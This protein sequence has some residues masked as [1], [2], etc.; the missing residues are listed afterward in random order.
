CGSLNEGDALTEAGVLCIGYLPDG[1]YTGFFV[2]H[3]ELIRGNLVGDDH[4]LPSVSE[5]WLS[6]TC[7]IPSSIVLIADETRL[8]N[9]RDVIRAAILADRSSEKLRDV[10]ITVANGHTIRLSAVGIDDSGEPFANSSSLSLSWGLNSCDGL[11]L[12]DDAYDI[13]E[14]NSWERFLVLQNE[15]GLCIVRATVTGFHDRLQSKTFHHSPESEIILTDAV[16][17]QVLF[18]GIN[19]SS[20]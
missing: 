4:P 7:S 11:A 18:A 8:M 12:W 17:L 19:C 20:S 3:W 16:R 13:V 2:K 6:V 14:P 1:V 10:P 5:A 15:S 9:E